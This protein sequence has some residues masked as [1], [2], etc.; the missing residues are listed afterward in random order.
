MRT[1]KDRVVENDDDDIGLEVEAVY[2]EGYASLSMVV[3]FVDPYGSG[4]SGNAMY[5]MGDGFYDHVRTD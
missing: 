3:D 1:D 4:A 2:E 5:W